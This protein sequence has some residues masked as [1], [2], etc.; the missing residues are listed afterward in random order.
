MELFGPPDIGKM[1]TERNVKGLIKALQYKG[2]VNVR[3]AAV[4]ALGESKDASA[5]GPL[6][7]ALRDGDEYVRMCAAWA[8]GSIGDA[9]AVESLV[10]THKDPSDNVKVY[11]VFALGNIGDISAIQPLLAAL[12]DAG[13]VKIFC[14]QDPRL[15]SAAKAALIAKSHSER[16]RQFPYITNLIQVLEHPEQDPAL[17][18]KVIETLACYLNFDK[19][20]DRRNAAQILAEVYRSGKLPAEACQTILSY[21]ERIKERH[22]DQIQH[23]D[24]PHIDESKTYF[25]SSDCTG[26]GSSTQHTDF[27]PTRPGERYKEIINKNIHADKGIGMEFDV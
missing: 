26:D 2:N 12:D 16:Y 1:K 17:A 21:R 19:L 7:I 4:T 8:L 3:R 27:F 18:V 25:Y 5:V 14:S 23:K 10:A 13:L 6:I 22:Q 20:K 24:G 11:S 15:Q 9:R